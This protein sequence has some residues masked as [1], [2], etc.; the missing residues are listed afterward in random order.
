MAKNNIRMDR[1]EN[2]HEGDEVDRPIMPWKRRIMT[3][4]SGNWNIFIYTHIWTRV[5][6][7]SSTHKHESNYLLQ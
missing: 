4:K 6:I 1:K 5:R 3:E 7:D 2:D